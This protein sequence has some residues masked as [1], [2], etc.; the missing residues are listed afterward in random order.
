MYILVARKLQL[1]LQEI[2]YV[3]GGYTFPEDNNLCF[4]P[5]RS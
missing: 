2:S 3:V 1:D 5:N 4:A